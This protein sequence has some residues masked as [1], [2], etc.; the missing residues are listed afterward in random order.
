MSDEDDFEVPSPD[1]GASSFKFC[2]VVP[3]MTLHDS[4]DN[5]ENQS[6][7]SLSNDDSPQKK[8]LTRKKDN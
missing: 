7:Y 3:P 4:D 5:D 8:Q 6:E 2:D 1:V